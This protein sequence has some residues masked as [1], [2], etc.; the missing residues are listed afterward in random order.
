[1]RIDRNR[2]PKERVVSTASGLS[3]E[4]EFPVQNFGALRRQLNREEIKVGNER[5]STESLRRSIPQNYFPL[6][7]KA[8]V[9][10]KTNRLYDELATDT[11]TIK[12]SVEREAELPRGE[13][14]PIEESPPFPEELRKHKIPT[15][16]TP[17]LVSDNY[18]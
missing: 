1:M 4:I 6:R 11:D 15:S 5:V 12:S 10:S 16:N 18:K 8:D 7:N 13:E 14:R 2:F 3:D 9:E 17:G